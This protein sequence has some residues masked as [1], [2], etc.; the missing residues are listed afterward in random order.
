VPPRQPNV[1]L[2]VPAAGQSSS[3]STRDTFADVNDDDDDDDDDDDQGRRTSWPQ[4]RTLLD[5]P[6]CRTLPQLSRHNSHHVDDVHVTPTLQA[7]TL[8][9]PRV[10]VRLGGS[11]YYVIWTL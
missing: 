1:H 7:P 6:S 5:R 4:V 11:E 8:L 10:R 9:V 2:P 3:R